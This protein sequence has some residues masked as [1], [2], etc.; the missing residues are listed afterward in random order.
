MNTPLLLKQTDKATK[1][2]LT[3]VKNLIKT[4]PSILNNIQQ[5]NLNIERFN[6]TIANLKNSLLRTRAKTDINVSIKLNTELLKTEKKQLKFYAKK[7]NLIQTAERNLNDYTEYIKQKNALVRQSVVR[8]SENENNNYTYKTHGIQ[9][10]MMRD[11]QPNMLYRQIVQYFDNDGTLTKNRA[12]PPRV[13]EMR[14]V[15]SDNIHTIV[16]SETFNGSDGDWKPIS[17]LEENDA[18]Y[19]IITTQ[20]IRP[21][22]FDNNNLQLAEQVFQLKEDNK[23]TCVIDACIKFFEARS[24]N[25]KAKTMLNRLKKNYSLYENGIPESEMAKFGELIQSS[26]NIIDFVNGTTKSFNKSSYN[27]FA[28]EFINTRFN[29]I[30]LLHHNYN[31]P[32]LICKEEYKLIKEN[33]PF[34]IDKFGTLTTQDKTYKL[35]STDFKDTYKNWYDE[36]EL[37]KK[38]IYSDSDEYN[39]INGYEYNMHNFFK[40]D[41]KADNNLYYEIDY[42]KAFYNYSDKKFNKHY[43]GI[44]SGSFITFKCSDKFSITDFNETE[45]IGFYH[46]EITNIKSHN[47]HCEKLGF[48]VG[49]THVLPTSNIDVLKNIVDFKFLNATLSPPCHIPFSPELL[50]VFNNNTGEIVRN[51]KKELT[52]IKGYCKAYGILLSEHIFSIEVKPLK[53]D[54]QYYNL[55]NNDNYD[56]YKLD[57]GLIKIFDKSIKQRRFKHVTYSIHGYLMAQMFELI[58]ALDI[59]MIVGIKLDSLILEKN[60]KPEFNTVIFDTKSAKIEKMINNIKNNDAIFSGS[61]FY[62]PMKT[63]NI[64]EY[65]FKPLPFKDINTIKKRVIMLGGAGGTGKT[66]SLLNAFLSLPISAFATTCWDLVE[67]KTSQNKGLMG[68]SMNKLTGITRNGSKIE[69]TEKIDNSRIKYIILDEATLLNKDDVECIIKDYSDKIIFILGDID[70]DDFYYQCSININIIK[71]SSLNCQ[72]IKF[73]KSYRFDNELNDKLNDLRTFMKTNYGKN[74]AIKNLNNYVKDNFS[75]CFKNKED[76][77][78]NENDIG[79]SG[80]NDF[81]RGNELTNYFIDRGTQVKYFIK[82]TLFQKGLFRGRELTEKPDNENYEAKLFKTIHSFQG[83]ELTHENKIIISVKNNFDYNLY[84]TALSRARRLDQI[85]ILKN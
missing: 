35:K 40:E 15:N 7:L 5:V 34:Y 69:K 23:K 37:D 27:R 41:V 61:A 82:T 42:K 14:T 44:P 31:E 10:Y 21:L 4:K 1:Q 2:Q 71:P 76:I 43:K 55:I 32:T 75:M 8:I 28:I 6:T 62:G 63:D 11:R 9:L 39:L 22:E 65:N 57:N 3:R 48:I 26:L 18:G 52:N 60:Y 73:T 47:L 85:I 19:T 49:T 79:I 17:F 58:F 67:K 68:Y 12:Y 84:Y 56:M 36:N 16:L 20:A 38:F 72:Y 33:E 54:I 81:K 59:N 24:E 80:L 45:L 64:N 78:F 74:G 50:N 70:E 13:F 29:H 46:V 77:V 25:P 51:D 30:E 53:D 66:T 83:C